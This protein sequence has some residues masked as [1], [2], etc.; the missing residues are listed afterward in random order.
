MAVA[1]VNRLKLETEGL[2]PVLTLSFV[3]L[4][5][6]LA[7]SLKG[8]GF[9]AVYL[10]GIVMGN[11]DFIHKRSLIHFH[12]GLAWLMQ[13]AMFVALG[14]L[15]FPS[16]LVPVAGIGFLIAGILMFV[17]RPLGVF[18]S[19]AFARMPLPEKL[20]VSWVG[21]RGAV[22][23]VLATFP[24]VAGVP[25]PELYFNV[26]FF[27]VLTSVLLQGTSIPLVARW[28]GLQAPM[29][30]RREYPLEYVSTGKSRNDLVE[31]PVHEASPVV[32][33]QIVELGL[34]RSALIVL[35]SRDDD[36]IVPR[37]GTVLQ[38]GDVMLVL[39]EPADVEAVRSIV[40]APGPARE[41]ASNQK[42]DPR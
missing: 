23:I 5:Y 10:A 36:F 38:A 16:Q 42:P 11:S 33:R 7:S 13:I 40:Q 26:V 29:T 14:L 34:P 6:G 15:V 18:L 39:G 27:V 8:N 24:S 20:L 19:L 37:G 32:G 1:V 9:L 28:L 2:Y 25:H 30:R 35:L 22:P 21:L 3:L 31:V 41:P 4:T 17:A 12:D